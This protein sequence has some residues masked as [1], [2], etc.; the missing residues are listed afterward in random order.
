MS[1]DFQLPG[2][3]PVIACGNADGSTPIGTV[4]AAPYGVTWNN[5]AAGSYA[6]TAKATDSRGAATTS[7]AVSITVAR[8]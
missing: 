6:L 4:N 7:Q 2:R 8:P 5:V 1:R 3:S